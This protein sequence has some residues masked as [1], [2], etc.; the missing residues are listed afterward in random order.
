MAVELS[1]KAQALL[2][3]IGINPQI[4]LDIEGVDLIFGAQPVLKVLSWDDENAFWDSGLTWDGLIADAKSRDYIS[5]NGTTTSI[6]QQIEPDKGSSSSISTVNISIVDVNGEVSKTLSFDNITEILGRKATFSI[7]MA[8]GSYP[9][10][11]QAIFRG[12]IVDFYTDSGT[13]MVSLASSESLKRQVLLEQAQ[14]ELTSTIDSIQTTIPVTLANAFYLSQDSMKS[15]IRI[16]DEIMEIITR[17][18][19]T[20]FTVSRSAL[21]TIADSHDVDASVDSFYRLQ[22]KPI[23][24]ALKLML[25]SSGNEFFNSLDLPKSINFVSVIEEIQNAVIFDYYDIREK[26]GLTVND[27]IQLNSTLNTG[28][29]TIKEFGYLDDGSSYIITNETLVTEADYTDDFSYK[30]KYNTLP[31]GLG[32]L[33]SEADVQQ[34][35]SIKSSFGSSFVDY[36]F[37]IK[38]SIDNAKEFI[39]SQLFFPQGLYS[40]PRKARSSV[41]F[42]VPPLTSEI[43]PTINV[44][45][46]INATSIKQRRS[47]HKYFY[48]TFLYRYNVDTLEDK[49]LQNRVLISTDSIDRINVGKKQLK[50]ESDGLRNNPE[51]KTLI[52]NISS[53]MNDRYRYAPVYYDNVMVKFKDGYSIEVGDVVPFGGSSLQM[54]D[55][56]TG[57]RGS[58]LQL[59]E[60][61]NKQLNVK[62]GKIS[63]SLISTSFE[64]NARYAVVSLA[65]NIDS[66]STQSRI[67]IIKTNDTQEY[68]NESDKW[69]EFV[70]QRVRV[71][72][73]DYTQDEITTLKEIDTTDNNYLKVDPPLS[74]VPSTNHTI[75]VPEYDETNDVIDSGY[76]LRFGYF[77]PQAEITSVIDAKTFNVDNPNKLAVGSYIY[78]HSRDYTTDSFGKKYK[79]DDITGS[80]VTLDKDLDFIPSIGQFVDNSNFKDGGFP[81]NIV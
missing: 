51:T 47:I 9:E 57:V 76:K 73:K 3:E 36:D 28:T 68:A 65:S 77:V 80:Q 34:F 55:L 59:F 31:T 19:D 6:T 11:A 37:Y 4:I 13:V 44:D 56:Q 23:D 45:S 50:I 33:T 70:G 63:L 25:S 8:Q 26:T 39:D 58:Q 72:S 17:D 20:Q 38:E 1:I 48:N 21:G 60:V 81:Y 14:T 15:Y 75:E 52:E 32:M 16:D 27:Y 61:I 62:D 35:E 22:G 30:S 5:L 7:G 69:K 79:I 74:F 10:D 64:I 29:Y 24:L 41:K 2:Q 54:T 40:I 42:I 46:I 78:V 12:V 71:V 66:G 67:K 53:R 43:V 49:Y 18:S